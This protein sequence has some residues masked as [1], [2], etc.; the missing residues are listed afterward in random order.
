MKLIAISLLLFLTGC[1]TVPKTTVI[2]VPISIPCKAE[3][4]DRPKFRFNPPYKN[5][6]DATKDLMGDRELSIAYENELRVALQSC[7]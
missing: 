5:I 2:E 3:E 4:P 6:F 7:K 1:V